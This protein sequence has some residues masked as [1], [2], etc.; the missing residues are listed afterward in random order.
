[1]TKKKKKVKKF[2]AQG[3]MQF[4]GEQIGLGLV[5][6]AG[7]A[8]IGFLPSFPGQAGTMQAMKPLRLVPQIHATGYF[9]GGFGEMGED[10]MDM[11]EPKKKR[12]K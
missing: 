4:T 11:F 8:M 10:M 6:N 12:K 9:I 5:S 3:L 1:M 2:S 7:P